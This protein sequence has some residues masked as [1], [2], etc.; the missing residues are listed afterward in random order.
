MSERNARLLRK[1][2]L[3]DKTSKKNWN[4]FTPTQKNAV[5]KAFKFPKDAREC[6]AVF[7]R[8]VS[9]R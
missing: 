1:M 7:S 4:E 6:V 8:F 9:L 2:E 5:R 3:N